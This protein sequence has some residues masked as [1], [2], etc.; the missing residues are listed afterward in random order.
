MSID[1]ARAARGLPPETSDERAARHLKEE[2]ERARLS[3]SAD[4]AT[5]RTRKLRADREARIQIGSKVLNTFLSEETLDPLSTPLVVEY[6]DT[7]SED[8]RETL[9]DRVSELVLIGN[10]TPDQVAAV[11]QLNNL[12]SGW[13]R[14][15]RRDVRQNAGLY[16]RNEVAKVLADLEAEQQPPAAGSSEPPRIVTKSSTV[17]QRLRGWLNRS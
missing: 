3:A 8:Q 5:E 1:E 6:F 10:E 12:L 14:G 2:E 13:D 17:W 16:H 7:Y 11:K 9:L 15:R 4:K